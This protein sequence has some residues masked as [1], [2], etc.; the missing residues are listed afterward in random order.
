MSV[1]EMLQPTGRAFRVVPGGYKETFNE[2]MADSEAQYYDDIASIMDSEYPDN[3]NFTEADCLDWERRLGLPSIG[4]LDER[5]KAI[6]R[7]RSFPGKNPARSHY[8]YLQKQLRDLG[9]D[10]Y[11]HENIPVQN[12]AVLNPNIFNKL[13]YNN[14]QYGGRRYGGF[15]NH[16]VANSIYNARDLNFNLGQNLKATFF[17]GGSVLGTYASIPASREI[18]FRQMILRIK[19]VQ[20]VAILYINLI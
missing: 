2:A 6:Q 16:L 4:T 18:E 19:P 17:I 11:V 13:Q 12:P 14:F 7:K 5:I 1:K 8:L 20:N 15:F 10:V 9:F 3:P